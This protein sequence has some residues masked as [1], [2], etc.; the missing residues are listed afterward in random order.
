MNGF[1]LRYNWIDLYKLESLENKVNWFYDIINEGISQY[2]PIRI[3]NTSNYPHWFS[4]ELINKVKQKN[5]THA[6]YKISGSK[7]AYNNFR[8]LRLECKKIS[9]ACYNNYISKT[10]NMINQD[11]S[12][13]WNFIKNKRRSDTDIPSSMAWNTI[14]ANNGNEVSNLFASFFSSI[15]E[16]N[17]KTSLVSKY[18]REKLQTNQDVNLSELNISYE[19][20]FNQLRKL[21]SRKGA[22]PDGIPNLSLKNC[23]PGLSEPITHIFSKSLELGVFPAT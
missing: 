5:T 23:A 3:I 12:K 16:N 11:T 19:N 13:F 1:F 21:Y 20:V 10:E 14:I 2:V 17:T 9:K 15:Y 6:K 8:N 7:I 4:N 18:Q 22:G